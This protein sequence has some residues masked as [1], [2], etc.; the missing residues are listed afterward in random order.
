MLKQRILSIILVLTLIFS[1]A[2]AVQ[3]AQD[4]MRGVWVS[5]IYNIDYPSA[6]GL[7]VDALKSEADT[8]L[9]NIAAMGLNTV[10]LQ[11][12]PS[13]DALYPSEIFPWSRYISGTVGQAPD[14]DFDVLA[15]WVE[16]AHSR[17]LQLHAWINPY[18]ITKD[19]Q[20]EWDALPENS[21][22]KQHPEWV[23]EY[24]D[25]YY[26]NPGLP[27]VQQ[28]VVDGAAEIVE[29]YD[30]DGI[31]L[32]DYFYP[33]TDFDDSATFARYGSDFSDI[34]DWRRDNVN[35][36]IA[37]LDE[38]LH[39]I[40]PALSF[41]VSPAGIWD[42]KANNP[43]GSETNGR[44]SYQEIYCD[45]VEWINK[46]TVDYICPQLYWSIGYEIADFEILVDWWQQVVSTSDVALYIGIGAYRA[47]EAEPGDVWYGTGELQR[48]LT[49]LD[50]SI[51]IQGEVFFSYSSLQKVD[52]CAAML[53]EH[54]AAGESTPDTTPET[55]VQQSSLLDLV[56]RFIASL[57]H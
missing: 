14:S 44:S 42:N 4:G 26:F 43:K 49:L 3:T 54:Y 12:R 15:Y 8:I 46:G 21:P 55:S 17:G 11:V 52:G 20:S 45:S 47:A 29:N 41:G 18:R 16:G 33:G 24:E 34:G 19:G 22:A 13:A 35:T 2:G 6:Q 50:D 25:N 5:T 36:L 51:D 38:T 31:H 56:S 10:F 7:S 27:A 48:Q 32:D 57:F 23:V 39:E 40:N 30:V 28:L 53:S 1:S 37:S 9:D